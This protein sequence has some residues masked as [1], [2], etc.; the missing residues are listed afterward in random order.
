MA[1]I[2]RTF[3]RKDQHSEVWRSRD[4]M[5]MFIILLHL[6]HCEHALLSLMNSVCAMT[7]LYFYRGIFVEGDD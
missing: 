5:F 3:G 2:T 4:V 7:L 6:K 1:V